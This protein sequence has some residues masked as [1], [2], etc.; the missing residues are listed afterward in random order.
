MA[1][2]TTLPVE[3]RTLINT[4]EQIT[5][6]SSPVHLRLQNASQ[7]NSIQKVTVY[8]WIWSGAQTKTL[9]SP[10]HILVKEKI[11][12]SDNYINFEISD[13]LKSYINP[14]FVY[15]EA[16]MPTYVG[17]G[18]FWQIVTDIESEADIVRNNYNT[19]FATLGYRWN[20]EQSYLGNNGTSEGRS[21]GY[22]G[23]IQR[24]YNTRIHDYYTQF[25]VLSN[26]VETAT[27]Q[28]MISQSYSFITNEF[29]KCV[30]DSCLIVYLDKRGLFEMFTPI[31][32]I[33]VSDKIESQTNN[34]VF[35]DPSTVDNSFQHSKL[36]D[37]LDVTQSYVINTGKL[38]ETM[39][40]IVE[41]IIYSPK[42]YLITFKGDLQTGETIGLTIDTTE[43]TIDDTNITIDS[44]TIGDE[45]TGKF[46][47]HQQIPVIVTD[48]D[49][50]RKTRINDKVEIDYNIKLEETNNKLLD[51][52]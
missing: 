15:N 32:K 41:E 22:L 29:E 19:S 49:F 37:N 21:N 39:V 7:D 25:F 8:L 17:Q 30:K 13:L 5:F 45:Y 11:S 24:W 43:V 6:C 3:D 48:S 20:Y 34:R 16:S 46:K 18:V 9:G 47:T 14:L 40:G 31:G 51:I 52:R 50:T 1:V 10:N 44:I 27:T 2:P 36:K 4:Q 35:R 28:N 33:T 38:R 42:V 23:T 26:S 12:A